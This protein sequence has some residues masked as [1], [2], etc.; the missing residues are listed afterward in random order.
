MTVMASQTLQRVPGGVDCGARQRWLAAPVVYRLGFMITKAPG[1]STILGLVVKA[2]P[3][4]LD[5]LRKKLGK[6]TK[7][8]SERLIVYARRLDE[9]RVFYFPYDMESE[10]LCISSLDEVRQFTDA[11]LADIENEA[12]RAAMGAILDHLRAFLDQWSGARMPRA[13]WDRPRFYR[14]PAPSDNR[15]DGID[16]FFQDLG[17]LRSTM[18]EMLALLRLVEPKVAAPNLLQESGA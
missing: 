18:K 11:T 14:G 10:A 17:E 16:Q 8:E 2:G 1:V 4:V 15:E 9:R 13:R 12:A 6:A 3:G 7:A 5:A